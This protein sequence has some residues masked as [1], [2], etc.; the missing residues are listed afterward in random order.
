MP[1]PK[2]RGIFF[3]VSRGHA[4][5]REH[6]KEN[7]PTLTLYPRSEMVYQIDGTVTIKT[8]EGQ[9]TKQ[10]PTFYLD[11]NI[12]GIRSHHH[13]EVIAK[14]LLN[15]TCNP[16]LTYSLT[17]FKKVLEIDNDLAPVAV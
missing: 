7:K 17:I 13:A 14:R 11:P 1:R 8:S 16:R 3:N 4:H 9:I 10:L 12:Q 5:V 15:P 2:G 6:V